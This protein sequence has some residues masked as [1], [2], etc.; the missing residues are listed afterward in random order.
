MF[1][2]ITILGLGPGEP[3]L[4]TRQAEEILKQATEVYLRTTRHPIVSALPA[5]ATIIS[6]DEYYER[7]ENFEDVYGQ[8][9]ERIIELGKRPEGVLYCVPGHPLVAEATSPEILRKAREQGIAARII[10]GMSFIEPTLSAL[11]VDPFPQTTFMDALQLVQTHHPPFTPAAP[12]IVAQLHSRYIASEVKLS[13]MAVYPDEHSVKLIHGAGTN[14]QVVETL[15]LYEIDRSEK[16]DILTCLFVPP[17]NDATSFESFQNVVA[18]LRAP[19]GCPWDIKQTHHSLRTH[20]LE[21][22]YELLSAIDVDDSSAIRE[23][24][25]DLLLQVIMHTQIASESGD[26]NMADVLYTV[27]TKI[28]RRHPHVFGDLKLADEQS[29]LQN[30]EKLKAEERQENGQIEKSL[31]DGV[32][33]SLPALVQALEYQRRAA[34]VGFD[35]P[36]VQGVK[37][38]INEEIEE[39]RQA[40]NAVETGE[41]I[42]DLLFAVTNLARHLNVDAESALRE[43]NSR[44][45]KRFTIMERNLRLRGQAIDQLS[46]SEMENEWQV[47]KQQEI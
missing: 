46:L 28:V 4:L 1:R 9:V 27:H 23:E 44:F 33:I 8:I 40:S 5:G 12:V 47:A 30:W 17:L 38:K 22:T 11:G 6:F 19:D 24:L 32:A 13:L 25:G 15:P 10:E 18:R 20:L 26:F 39:I 7:E 31:L 16:I 42:G 43:A 34:R 29:V 37:D 2:G 45:R 21:E 35:W 3:E 36:A 14:Q 41:E